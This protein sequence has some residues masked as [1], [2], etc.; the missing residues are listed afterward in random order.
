MNLNSEMSTE[1]TLVMPNQR[2][3]QSLSL[4]Q[5]QLPPIVENDNAHEDELDEDDL[6]IQEAVGVTAFQKAEIS[7]L[8]KLLKKAYQDAPEANLNQDIHRLILAPY[9]TLLHF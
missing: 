3:L 6:E 8:R 7:K 1:Q 5:D 9:G 2:D 4:Q